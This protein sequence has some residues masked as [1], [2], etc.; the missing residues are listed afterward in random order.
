MLRSSFS[1]VVKEEKK[2]KHR[3]Y[4]WSARNVDDFDQFYAKVRTGLLTTM[5][6]DWQ[7]AEWLDRQ[8]EDREHIRDQ[9]DP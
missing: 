3:W 8:G 2:P 1:T 9:V 4:W 6:P 5:V 7:S